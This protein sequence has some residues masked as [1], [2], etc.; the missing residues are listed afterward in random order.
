MRFRS[1]GSWLTV[2][3]TSVT[4]DSFTGGKEAGVWADHSPVCSAQ[5]K[6]EWSYTFTHLVFMA[7]RGTAW[8]LV[9]TEIMEEREI[10]EP[11]AIICF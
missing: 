9:F 2:G 7:S 6:N 10:F 8:P 11:G 3:P 4:G 1:G 5:V